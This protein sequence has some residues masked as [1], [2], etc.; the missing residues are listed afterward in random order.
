MP[1]STPRRTVV[2]VA[3]PGMQALDLVGPLEVFT[4][5]SHLVAGAY[6]IQVVSSRQGQLETSSGLVL[7]PECGL[8]DPRAGIDTVLVTGGPGVA[9]AE[10]D[11]RLINWLRDASRHSRRLASVCNG[12]LLLARA[13][14]LDGRGLP[15]TGP[16]PR[17]SPGVIPG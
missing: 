1:L 10:R 12:A 3:F 8:P 6:E 17:S 15:H 14:L 13:G 7:L 9:V 5:A 11:A 4:G 2:M 16:P